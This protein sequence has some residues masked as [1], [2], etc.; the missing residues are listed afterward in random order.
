MRLARQPAVDHH[1]H[2]RQRHR[3]LGHV[4]GQHHAA[5]ALRVG[6]QHLA[7]CLHRQLAVQRQQL[8]RR[9]QRVLQGRLHACDLALTGQEHQHVARMRGQRMFHRAAGLRL[10]RF[11]AARWK[12]RHFHR[13]A[14]PGTAQPRG[15]EKTGQALAIQRGRHRHDAQVLAHLALHIQRQR[16]TQVAGQMPFVEFVEEQRAHAFQH[17]VVLQHAGQDA[18]GDHLD[19]RARGGLVLEADAVA[20]GLA[21]RLAELARHE[22][23]GAARGHP[24]WFQ[25]HDAA[26]RQPGRIQQRQRHLG[27]LAGAGRRFQHQ[28]R[29]GGEAVADLR[30]QRGNRKGGVTHARQGYWGGV[31]RAMTGR[32][33]N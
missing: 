12:M 4:G 14:A 19:P 29:M 20:H 3:R 18:L 2:A 26:A 5:P 24:A 17:R 9:I 10:Q 32:V 31:A 25:H 22:Q 13:V 8:Q 7:L 11:V 16:Q 28:T 15:I 6:L 23:R 21:D 27:G 33:R 1:A 30:Q